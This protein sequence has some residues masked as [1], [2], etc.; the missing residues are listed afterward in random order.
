MPNLKS[1]WLL[2]AFVAAFFLIGIPFWDIP[3]SQVSVPNS[4]VAPGLIGLVA[5]TVILTVFEVASL[6]RIFVVMSLCLPVV[7]YARVEVETGRD[8]TS[9]NLWP[10]EVVF[11]LVLG[12]IC[13]LP[14][15]LIGKLAIRWIRKGA[16]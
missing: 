8:P 9:H 13:V 3:Y 12:V 7:V 11:A 6:R 4:L 1:L 2:P 16:T 10:F 14:A 15:L 5:L